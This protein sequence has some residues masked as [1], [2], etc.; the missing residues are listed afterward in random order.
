M[1]GRG[2]QTPG[3]TQVFSLFETSTPQ[4]FLDEPQPPLEAFQPRARI[5]REHGHAK[6]HQSE[7]PFHQQ[8]SSGVFIAA[9]YLGTTSRG[10]EVVGKVEKH[11]R[12]ETHRIHSVERTAVQGVPVGV[13]RPPW[14]NP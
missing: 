8:S 10:E 2:M 7:E 6:Q 13:G 14:P 4:L 11:R 5:E 1:M 12:C 3:L 9:N